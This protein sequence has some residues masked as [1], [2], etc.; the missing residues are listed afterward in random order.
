M[1]RTDSFTGKQANERL[2]KKSNFIFMSIRSFIPRNNVFN[3]V[4]PYSK[5]RYL[6]MSP[7]SQKSGARESKD[8]DS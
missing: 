6:V 3:N 8:S 2:M 1:D 5:S 4:V 7:E